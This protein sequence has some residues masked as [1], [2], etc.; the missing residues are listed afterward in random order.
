MEKIRAYVINHGHMDIEWYQPL[1]T[2][3]EW[4][5]ESLRMLCR[6]TE[7]DEEYR[8]Y[9]L[10]GA[11]FP[12]LY[13]MQTD[14]SLQ[15]DVKALIAKG[16][17]RIGP[18]YTQFD[19]FLVCGEN[20]IKNCL[21]GD[22]GSRKLGAGPM[23]AGYL[24]DNF[25]HPAQLPQILNNFGIR[26]LFFSR[27]MCDIAN[28]I[29]EFL[30]R[31]P[32]GS[33]VAAQNFSY[34]A[35]F[36]IYENND[37]RPSV[38][39]YLPFFKN[40]YFTY[41][42]LTDLSIHRDHEGIARQLIDGVRSN[43]RFY[44]SGIVPVFVGADHCPPQEG[45]TETLRLANGMQEEIEFLFTDAQKLS[46]VLYAEKDRLPVF[47]GDLIGAKYAE[48]FFGAMTTRIYLKQ[49]MYAC[50]RLLFDYALPLAAYAKWL[51]H[52]TTQDA[53]DEATRLL[54]I[55]SAHDSIHGAGIEAVHRENE[56]RFDRAAQLCVSSIH[57]SLK[58][59]A[60]HL[61][62]ETDCDEIAVYAPHDH[63]G[64]VSAW[65]YTGAM[66]PDI[67][68]PSGN[69]CECAVVPRSEVIRNANGQP[70][71][72]R[73]EG[74]GD[75]IREVVFR[76]RLFAG[77]VRKFFYRPS[78]RR[79][80]DPSYRQDGK[81]ENEFY[82]LEI[83]G[84]RPVLTD[85]TDDR[86]MAGFL[87]FIEDA[88]A[89]D[90]FDHCEPW[91]GSNPYDSDE[92]GYTDVRARD[93]GV[94]QEL[95]AKCTMKVPLETV[96]DDRSGSLTDLPIL[97]TFRLWKGIRRLDIG[98][99]I[100]NYARNHRVRAVFSFPSDLGSVTANELF[101][102]EEFPVERPPKT[103][104]WTEDPTRELPFRD[105]VSV[106]DGVSRCTV[107]A[108]GLYTFETPDR[109]S[110]A[111][112]LFRSVGELMRIN[113]KKRKGCC[114]AGYPVDRAQCLADMA[115]EFSLFTHSARDSMYEIHRMTEQF[116]APPAVHTFRKNEGVSAGSRSVGLYRFIGNA[117]F[118]VSLFELS[119]DRDH[120]LLR[121][122]ET[123]GHRETARIDLSHFS[124]VFL[125]DM[126]ETVR[127]ELP[128]RDG[129]VELD[130]A[131]YQVITL[132][133]K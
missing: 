100:R 69:P 97:L 111:F 52:E 16:K 24:P 38:P 39:N 5:C 125:S 82:S 8:C 20:M 31:A 10:D 64:Y 35:S 107:S 51:G 30:F 4:F 41:E 36:R 27:G 101:C 79:I 12:V 21:W 65:I 89:G 49:R 93:C 22:R 14:P 80:C 42:Y 105:W 43:A 50:E 56:Y 131:A 48:L 45:L 113:L 78:E 116:I 129:M 114:S 28:G 61:R 60:Q 18:F 67:T 110:I 74:D 11:V 90:V 23:K 121:F 26:S 58:D 19:E 128:M 62:S 112:T 47:S 37:P 119:Y 77:Q 88:E 118:A 25:G 86:T 132:L 72:V 130:V 94:Y 68:D 123:N 70:Y 53:L 103:E 84:G 13:A 104:G 120:F 126:N 127:D 9:V 92:F 57:H 109:H 29:R 54:L 83:R 117:S 34:G 7:S 63:D 32:D 1:T 99:R 17:L 124:R 55:N 102:T 44:P 106:Q 6:I 2:Y 76:A 73:P 59:I 115:F 98:V 3:G 66:E 87:R 33:E 46:D 91:K 133:M 40:E 71:Y 95:S 85:R 15:E 81:I 96:G 75:H 108:K 122:Y